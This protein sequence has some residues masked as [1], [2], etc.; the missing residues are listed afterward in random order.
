MRRSGV[1]L[2][3]RTMGAGGEPEFGGNFLLDVDEFTF[4]YQ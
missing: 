1:P 2:D 3:K 4:E